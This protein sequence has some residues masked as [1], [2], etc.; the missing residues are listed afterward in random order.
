MNVKLI[1]QLNTCSKS[2]I[3]RDSP[4][5]APTTTVNYLAPI[6]K[7]VPPVQPFR[8]AYPP[9]KGVPEHNEVLEPHQVEINDIRR[10]LSDFGLDQSGFTAWL[11][12]PTSFDKWNDDKAI[13]SRYY[14]ETIQ[15]IKDKLGA[16]RVII[17][18][19]YIAVIHVDQTPAAGEA[20]IRSHTDPEEAEKLLRTR[21]QI[22]N[23]WRPMRGPVVD[24]PL[25]S[26]DV[27]SVK[28]KDLGRI[29]LPVSSQSPS[30]MV[31]PLENAARRGDDHQG[32]PSKA[33]KGEVMFI[34]DSRAVLR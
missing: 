11:D 7:L 8:Y 12:T 27:R 10:R 24:A 30:Q 9:P 16:T 28:H 32:E 29:Y 17:D 20:R 26:I 21:A 4:V 14:E 19:L 1:R 33:R 5:P 34:I 23:I 18:N 3:C 13:R 25:G 31:L 15:L 22:L 2:V 6:E